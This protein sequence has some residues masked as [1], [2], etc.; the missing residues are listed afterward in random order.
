VQHQIDQRLL[1][2]TE[3]HQ[4]VFNPY[5]I[6]FNTN[7][8]LVHYT[9]RYASSISACARACG[10]ELTIRVG[11]DS[12]TKRHCLA[13]SVDTMRRLD[14]LTGQKIPQRTLRK[15]GNKATCTR[16]SSICSVWL[17]GVSG[18]VD[19]RTT[20][21]RDPTRNALVPFSPL[22]YVAVLHHLHVQ[23]AARR[24]VVRQRTAIYSVPAANALTPCY[25]CLRLPVSSFG[26]VH[27]GLLRAVIHLSMPII[28]RI[29]R[30]DAHVL[31]RPEGA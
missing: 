8:S 2:Q 27:S 16:T 25:D 28:A 29:P 12:D 3:C 22:S 18:G 1:S 21:P 15:Q 20:K 9:I 23:S 19:T 13:N 17:G 5:S 10:Y 31:V 4:L 14:H 26:C 6:L 24:L 30:A 11:N 7:W